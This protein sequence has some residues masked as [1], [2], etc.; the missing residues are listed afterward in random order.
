MGDYFFINDGEIIV[1]QKEPIKNSKS[2]SWSL[3]KNLMNE[4]ISL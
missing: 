1:E 2:F 4:N 3:M